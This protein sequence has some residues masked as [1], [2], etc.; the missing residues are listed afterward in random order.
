M[1]TTA[2]TRA[3]YAR[4]GLKVCSR[5]DKPLPLSEFATASRRERGRAAYCRPC[6]NARKKGAKQRGTRTYQYAL[7]HGLPERFTSKLVQVD[8]HL[9][10][11]GA[12]AKSKLGYGVIGFGEAVYST[13]RV[14]YEVVKGPIPE[15]YVI[16]HL[17]RFPSCVNPDH[18][19][20][21]THQ[22]NIKRGKKS[23]LATKCPQGH[24]YGPWTETPQGGR[25]RRCPEC[26]RRRARG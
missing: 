10:W 16:D 24:E 18:L 19:E 17:C 8:A 14:A 23:G 25:R 15:G 4:F 20:A 9:V 5:C 6:K 1:T 13:H 3:H 11:I 2:A 21:V 12:G 7:E 22:E 26:D